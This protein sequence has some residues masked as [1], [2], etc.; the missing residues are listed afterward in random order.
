[1]LVIGLAA[2]KLNYIF[3]FRGKDSKYSNDI[4]ILF[5]IQIRMFGSSLQSQQYQS[6][7]IIAR[8]LLAILVRS[9]NQTYAT[10]KL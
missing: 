3:L 7:A 1:M 6:L 4:R 2:K 10:A 5:G 8:L 9:I